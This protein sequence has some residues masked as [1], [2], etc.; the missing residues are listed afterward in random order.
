[1]EAKWQTD[2]VFLL[3]LFFLSILPCPLAV[4][5]ILGYIYIII[6]IAKKLIYMFLGKSGFKSVSS[7]FISPPQSGTDPEITFSAR[8]TFT[9][10]NMQMWWIVMFHCHSGGLIFACESLITGYENA[11]SVFE[12]LQRWCDMVLFPEVPLLR[13][14]SPHFSLF[15][16]NLPVC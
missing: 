10:A 1:M 9:K 2:S 12:P 7:S 8:H 11:E 5:F 16:K 15:E 4:L 13:A 6:C 14:F 3:L